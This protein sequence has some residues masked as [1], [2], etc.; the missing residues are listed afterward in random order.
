MLEV[1]NITLETEALGGTTF[2]VSRLA[3]EE[4]I[5]RLFEFDILV[6]YKG[7]EQLDGEDLIGQP[8]TI[9]FTRTG[10]ETRRIHGMISAVNDRFETEAKFSTYRLT[11]VP[12]AYRLTLVE[13]LD[14]FLDLNL[15]DLI[16]L[17][18]KGH[19][20]KE[21]GGEAIDHDYELR[22]YEQYP[23]RDLFV[24]YKETDLQFIARI[25]EHYGVSYFFEHEG[26]RDVMI[27]TDMNAGMRPAE[28]AESIGYHP[29]GDQ[30]EVYR[31]E[32]KLHLIPSDYIVR[33]YNYRTPQADLT[34]RAQTGVGLGHVVEYGAHVKTPEE[35]DLLAVVRME[36]RLCQRRVFEGT[37][38]IEALRSAG[39]SRLIDHPLGDVALLV[40]EVRHDA[41]L[42][43]FG[44][45]TGGD[46]SVEGITYK[47]EF[48]AINERHR[49][50]PARVTPKP[51]IHGVVNAVIDAADKGQYAE[52][53]EQGRYRV[54]FVFDTTGPG[55]GQASR[56][57]RMAQ[58]H[59]GAGYGMHFPLRPGVE[60]LLSFVDGDPDRPII[61]SAVPNPQTASPVIDQNAPRNVIRTGGGNEINIDDTD[62]SQR[63]KLHSPHSSTT[64]QLGAPN[65]PERGAVLETWG[66]QTNFAVS[67][68]STLGAFSSTLTLA[69]NTLS[70][71]NVITSA[72]G[73][74]GDSFEALLL[75]MTFLSNAVGGLSDTALSVVNM[76]TKEEEMELA[77]KKEGL[78]KAQ[79]DL[80]R[81]IY[82]SDEYKNAP[83]K[84]AALARIR[85]RNIGNI[86]KANAWN[87]AQEIEGEF[88]PDTLAAHKKSADRKKQVDAI[89]LEIDSL[90]RTDPSSP[91]LAGKLEA[92]SAMETHQKSL[93][94]EA[95]F[96]RF[97]AIAGPQKEL[98]TTL[99]EIAD[100]KARLADPA[101]PSADRLALEQRLVALAQQEAQQKQAVQA[102]ID[103]FPE[104]KAQM[105]VLGNPNATPD[106]KAAAQKRLDGIQRMGSDGL[107]A[108]GILDP[109]R[110]PPA[111]PA[112]RARALEVLS[113][114]ALRAAEARRRA[115][116][117][118]PANQAA[119]DALVT[120]LDAQKKEMGGEQG[121]AS[122]SEAALL[123][124]P[125]LAGQ[126]QVQ[127][128]QAVYDRQ[129][130]EFDNGE[131][132]RSLKE[133]KVRLDQIKGASDYSGKYLALYSTIMSLIGA[134][135]EVKTIKKVRKAWDS[136]H[137]LL[138][139]W[140]SQYVREDRV[141]GPAGPAPAYSE[142]G[143]EI[144][145]SHA[146]VVMPST[147]PPGGV[148][149][150]VSAAM[151]KMGL[152]EDVSVG[153]KI[154]LL[155]GA[156][157]VGSLATAIAP[158]I[159]AGALGSRVMGKKAADKA[160]AALGMDDEGLA[161]GVD[162]EKIYNI[163]TAKGAAV[164]FGEVASVVVGR[165]TAI[166][167]RNENKV[168]E[169]AAQDKKIAGE[170]DAKKKAKLVAG[171]AEAVGKKD[172]KRENEG[173][174][175]IVGE[176]ATLV[177]SPGSTEVCG[178]EQALMTSEVEVSIVSHEYVDVA[179][180]KRATVLAGALPTPE[181]GAEFQGQDGATPWHVTVGHVTD[182]NG[183]GAAGAKWQL[184]IKDKEAKL[185]GAQTHLTLTDQDAKLEVGPSLNVTM[186][187][188][189]VVVASGGTKVEV[190]SG[191]V[192]ITGPKFN[193]NTPGNSVIRAV[194]HFFL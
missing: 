58:P 16:R 7:D 65:S 150:K 156:P 162:T 47:N 79:E 122:P 18:L 82:G 137:G 144:K 29:R 114:P 194:R 103:G 86:R 193:V 3:G 148:M 116:P 169:D 121:A 138:A 12:R 111:S 181:W 149:S 35:A 72:K 36:E 70:A 182:P 64:F 45:G 17:K 21:A 32:E 63:V 33:D 23:L 124:D 97:P 134:V 54:K 192:D 105:D 102:A 77:K 165:V 179:A 136:G 186:G 53:D 74:E 131:Y 93:D 178:K 159:A 20:M 112:D 109:N 11:F 171:K 189:A 85:A 51:R 140:K 168:T 92:L 24:Q 88:P 30:I 157:V 87:R 90:R 4:A 155:L 142:T 84:G 37:S 69:A 42:A 28:R 129:K 67:G 173:T 120:E 25:C 139:T 185:G 38:D 71:G 184:G 13:T 48:K 50:R 152:G 96:A 107:W 167:A 98:N 130:F 6:A 95:K 14:V 49:Y 128:A 41:A 145:M 34:G 176:T 2:E 188:Q 108:E 73:P 177:S 61:T 40:T 151:D 52:L 135:H 161:I 91:L 15:P 172:V 147:T 174:V 66:A 80:D 164:L 166:I 127:A 160:K 180:G 110:S 101:L 55:E 10:V 46:E 191:S 163:Q 1:R 99:G 57:V 119:V 190:K 132:V 187:N 170:D 62:G 94:Q 31:F 75:G 44:A 27:F 26:G 126:L 8:A 154:P 118:D 78:T 68:T 43:S 22:L 59:A 19:D 146:N 113:A 76:L 115:N 100:A 133:A 125:M 104:V 175:V 106:E 60:V 9:I 117:N 56:L 158:L 141:M 39:K 183:G 81:Q 89:K 83:D 5:S 123:A 143:A 153:W